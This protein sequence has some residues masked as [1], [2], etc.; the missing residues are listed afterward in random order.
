MV[1]LE[2]DEKAVLDI[3]NEH[4]GEA[5]AI[6][7]DEIGRR[8]KIPQSAT[9]VPVRDIVSQILIKT[10]VPIGASSKGFFIIA[11]QEELIRY[12]GAL[13]NRS[14]KIIER[15]IRV[16]ENFRRYYKVPDL[17]VLKEDDDIG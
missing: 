14:Q 8:L 3:L 17:D 15:R 16:N 12:E 5:Y 10:D 6:S 7:A 2:K 4:V 1:K 13:D 11:I 9:H